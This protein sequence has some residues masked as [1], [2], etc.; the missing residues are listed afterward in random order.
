MTYEPVKP[1]VFEIGVWIAS[2]PL[3]LHDCSRI[4]RF[5]GENFDREILDYTSAG[6]SRLS[7]LEKF[8]FAKTV[9]R[10]NPLSEPMAFF[11]AS[12]DTTEDGHSPVEFPVARTVRSLPSSLMEE[13]LVFPGVCVVCAVWPKANVWYDMVFG[14]KRSHPGLRFDPKLSM[15]IGTQS[16]AKEVMLAQFPLLDG[17]LN[18]KGNAPINSLTLSEEQHLITESLFG[19][20]ERCMEDDV[21]REWKAVCLERNLEKSLLPAALKKSPRM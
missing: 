19:I 18:A 7:V 6:P 17:A 3:D 8:R 1:V 4:A 14:G 2:A 20:I 5:V 15:T 11:G 10:D 21:L 16:G 13:G 12:V 9:T